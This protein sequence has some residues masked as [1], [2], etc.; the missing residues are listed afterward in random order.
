MSYD[1]P[2]LIIAW[3]RPQ[4][5]RQVINAIR[6]LRPSRLFFACDGP[7][8][9]CPGEAQKI[10]ATKRLIDDEINWPCQIERRYSTVNQGC[11]LGPIN[12]ISWF[13]EHVC[14]GIILEDD[15]VPHISFFSYCSTLLEL[16]RDDSRVWCISGN[17]FQN[18]QW[19]GDGSYYFSGYT[20][21]W[22]WAS[23]RQC[24]NLYDPYMTQW[25][26]LR[27]SSLLN[28]IF[29]D[30]L[31]RMYWRHIWDKTYQGKTSVTWWDYQWAFACIIHSGLT[32]LPNRNLVRNVGF[33][34]DATH[35][36]G[37]IIETSVNKGIETLLHPSFLVKHSIADRYTFYSAYFNLPRIFLRRIALLVQLISS[38]IR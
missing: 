36:S 21:S 28:S 12:A 18:G 3:R 17:N 20:H 23:W 27:N 16:Y 29:P 14:E 5:L 35:T 7:R 13:F 31:E 25:P 38:F 22:G 32:A 33:G 11:R 1:V 37:M 34:Q 26:I 10:L 2:I 19:R 24:W 8:P 30:P 9:D 6:P 4:T 15:C